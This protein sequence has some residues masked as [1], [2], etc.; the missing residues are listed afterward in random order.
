MGAR[1][2]MACPCCLLQTQRQSYSTYPPKCAGCAFLNSAGKSRQSKLEKLGRMFG[3][4]QPLNAPEQCS[5][6]LK[7]QL[8]FHSAGASLCAAQPQASATSRTG[9]SGAGMCTPSRVIAAPELI[10]FWNSRLIGRRLIPFSRFQF[11]GSPLTCF[12]LLAG[13]REVRSAF[14]AHASLGHLSQP[15]CIDRHFCLV[16]VTCAPSQAN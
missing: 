13:N 3:P 10:P 7:P 14:P 11:N 5:A 2:R 16:V 9:L 15:R 12:P 6:C 4:P 8:E 1:M